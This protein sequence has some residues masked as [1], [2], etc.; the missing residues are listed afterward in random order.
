MPRFAANLSLLFT[1]H[2]LADRFA[3]AAEAGFR[4][5]EILFPYEASPSALAKAREDAGL[6][7]ALINTPAGDW[8]GGERGLAGLPGREDEFR[9]SFEMALDYATALEAPRLHCLAGIAPEGVEA[10]TCRAVFTANLQWASEQAEMLGIT[11]MI[12]AI[13][14]HDM[15]GYLIGNPAEALAVMDT[16]RRPNIAFQCDLYHLARLELPVAETALGLLPVTRHIQFA[17]AP[18]R[19][20]PG[21]G[22]LDL[23]AIFAALDE[24]GYEG[25]VAAEYIPSTSTEESLDW[26]A[27]Y[28]DAQ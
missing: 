19:H 7:V 25:W 3:A 10:E 6:A 26:F 16:L 5:A 14:H 17:D 9:E 27:A 4:G 23:R 8:A 1:E 15:P 20:E 21:T 13:N 22:A 28:R 18:G 12:E 2:P 11:V 24:A